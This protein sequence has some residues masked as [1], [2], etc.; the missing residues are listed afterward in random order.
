M[1]SQSLQFGNDLAG[2]EGTGCWEL[3]GEQ[4]RRLR[5]SPRPYTSPRF[6]LTRIWP[7]E[8]VLSPKRTAAPTPL[9]CLAGGIFPSKYH[10][11]PT[12][13]LQGCQRQHVI[14]GE[15]NTFLVNI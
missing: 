10:G 8:G 7:K 5:A 13:G 1:G 12:E 15:K 4:S 3:R 2:K 11:L 6:G 14:L 9:H